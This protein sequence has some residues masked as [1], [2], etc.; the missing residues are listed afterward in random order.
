LLGRRAECEV[1]NRLLSG[2]RAERGGVLVVHGEAGVGKTAL[3]QYAIVAT[4]SDPIA[5]TAGVEAEMELPFAAVHQLCSTFLTLIERLPEPQHDALSVAFGLSPGRPPSRFLVGLAV[6][7][8]LAEAAEEQPLMCVVD[9]AQWLDSASGG[10][11]GFVA[12]RLHT[13]RIALLFATRELGETLA[14]LPAMRVEPLDRRDARELLDSV[15]PG[16][17]DERVAERIVVET[18]GNPLALLELPRDL[19]PTQL[20][21]GFSMPQAAP[22]SEGVQE[23]FLRRVARLP[24]AARR[25]LLVAAAD[26]VGDPALVW[27]AAEHLGVP[28]SAV[29]TLESAGLVALFPRV[30]FRHPLVRSAVYGS[31]ELGERRAIHQALAD[32]TDPARDPDRR[33]WHRAHAASAPDEDV[34]GELEQSA[35]RAQ[36]RGGLAAA[37]AFLERAVALTP[38]P[39]RRA[40]RAL[41]ATRAKVRAGALDDALALV[42]IAGSG[43]AVDDRTRAEV[44]LLRAQIE[45]TSRHGSEAPE[46]LLDAASQLVSLDVALARQTY[47]DALCAAM[48]AGHLAGPGADARRVASAA[49]A[50]PQPSSPPRVPDL[51]LDG[52]ATL[53]AH[54]YCA[55]VPI[56]R[57]ALRAFPQDTSPAEQLRW[58]WPAAISAVLLWDDAGWEM[59]AQRHVI[60]AR[61][62][63][64]LAE[65]PLGLSQRA[66]AHM[67]A[68]ELAPAASLIEE[69]AA[70]MQAT[71]SDLAPYA[72]VGLAALE[73]RDGVAVARIEAGRADAAR[74][75]EGIGIS[76]LDWAEAVL[77]NGLGRYEQACVAAQRIAQHPPDLD[78]TNWWMA[79]LIEAA[80]RAGRPEL[81]V[82]AH[83]RLREMTQASGGEWALGLEA[84]SRALLSTGQCAESLYR[85]ALARLASTRIRTDLARTHLLYGEWLRRERRRSD[86]RPQ[87]RMAYELFQGFGMQA[88][89]ERAR[90]ELEAAGE[91]A[92][93]HN[94]TSENELTPQETQIARLAVEGHA[95]REIAARLFISASTV[96]YHLRKVFRK[97]GVTSRTQL[98]H[99]LGNPR[100]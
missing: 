73:G 45:F 43:T 99:R 47:L 71:G 62:T 70:A 36:A 55:A 94:A 80:V 17:L 100:S 15:L 4:A 32:A 84:R 41:A 12:R 66:Y 42:D 78:S 27:R 51:L 6:L 35:A 87:L 25:L 3:L 28:A 39:S 26:P 88:F 91:H 98:P 53:Y 89:L 10:I 67:F 23:S 33:A 92:R 77:C 96:E 44:H 18:R 83:L 24:L 9:D 97:L 21:G 16:P 5:E 50:A 61:E 49:L 29:Q 81:A 72:A 34:A 11:L 7:G 68:G 31:A 58:L 8:L 46:L 59:V 48:F 69:I 93:R 52:L 13:E 79:E 90:R 1:I 82:D 75:G 65:L 14:G 30:A 64:A 76:V 38:E 74:R 40:Q 20:A 56:L 54:G 19:T 85:E 95:N 22:V 57:R 63:G 60:L 86:A 37:A 2:V